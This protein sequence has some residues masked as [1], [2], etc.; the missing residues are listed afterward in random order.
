MKRGRQ[1][2][3]ITL[4]SV[5]ALVACGGNM[6]VDD[7]PAG[8]T[9]GSGGSGGAETRFA[10]NAENC[11]TSWPAEG[12]GCVVAVGQSCSFHQPDPDNAGYIMEGLCGCWPSSG[13]TLRWHCYKD[14]SG[15]WECPMA[16]PAE[17]D[18]C[19][20]LY[21]AT[22]YYPERTNCYCST[23]SGSWSCMSERLRNPP[24]L[25]ASLDVN[26]PLSALTPEERTALCGWYVSSRLGEGFPEDPP[27][28]VG[29]DGYIQNSG[30]STGSSFVCSAHLPTIS[31][32]QCVAN[33]GFTSCS[34]SIGELADCA[35]TVHDAC[36]PAEH[37]C[38]PYFDHPD[39]SGTLIVEAD[40]NSGTGGTG[41][42]DPAGNGASTGLGRCSIRVQ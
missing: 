29:P 36:F 2:T 28:P 42:S 8:G 6:V 41:G 33:L 38:A 40:P 13:G 31:R 11:P 20:G 3:S 16:Q 39:C 12:D 34:A 37:G 15:P 17:G 5:L 21:G 7:G 19:F 26:K 4:V 32:E 18:N 35:L 24:A 1:S 9:G 23:E 22:C 10:G 27:A 25:P 14:Q 30:C